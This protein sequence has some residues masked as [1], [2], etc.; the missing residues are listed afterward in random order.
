MVDS[1]AWTGTI[2]RVIILT[3]NVNDNAKKREYQD[4][5]IYYQ[6]EEWEMAVFQLRRPTRRT[7]STRWSFLNA[8][9]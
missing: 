1:S 8:D 6:V 9:L 7:G 5:L 2:P 3:N 4:I